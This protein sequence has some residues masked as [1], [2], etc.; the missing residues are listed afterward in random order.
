LKETK[1][2]ITECSSSV[3]NRDTKQGGTV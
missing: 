2:Y 1:Y 3:S